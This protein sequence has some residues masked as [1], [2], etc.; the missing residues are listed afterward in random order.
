MRYNKRALRE[1]V[2]G[3]Q[4]IRQ[5]TSFGFALCTVGVTLGVTVGLHL[6]AGY[7]HLWPQHKAIAPAVP[8]PKHKLHTPYLKRF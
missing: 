1:L 2:A 7:F 6:S 5:S 8:Q 4:D 3:C